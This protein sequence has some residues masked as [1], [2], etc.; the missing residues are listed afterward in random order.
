MWMGSK[1]ENGGL[2]GRLESAI[3]VKGKVIEERPDTSP[4][5]TFVR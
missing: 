3:G 5:R 2:V 4:V 1:E